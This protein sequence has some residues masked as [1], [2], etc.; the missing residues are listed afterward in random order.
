MT[1][2]MLTPTHHLINR[3][4]DFW[5]ELD[6]LSAQKALIEQAETIAVLQTAL[7]AAHADRETHRG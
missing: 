4:V 7:A 5:D 1:E 6:V 2:N 3:R